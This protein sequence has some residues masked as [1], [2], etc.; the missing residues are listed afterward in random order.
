MRSY[1]SRAAALA[2]HLAAMAGGEPQARE[3]PEL[4]RI[5]VALPARL[6]EAGRR[7]LLAALADADRYG[8]DLTVDG[9]TLWVEIGRMPRCP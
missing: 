8:H 9:A 2:A 5:G 1:R 4:I 6:S 3:T 7:A